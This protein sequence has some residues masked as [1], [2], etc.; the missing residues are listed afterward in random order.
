MSSPS[1]ILIA[2]L[3]WGLGHTTRCLPIIDFLLREGHAVTLAAPQKIL[4][5]VAA[6]FP[7][8]RQILLEGYQIEYS[9]TKAFFAG[10]II[11]Q[12]PKILGTIRREHQWLQELQAKEHFDLIISDNRYGLHHPGLPCVIMTHQLLIKS[13]FGK[14][15][16]RQLQKFHY[17][18]LEKFNVCWVVDE[19]GTINLSGELAHPAHLP[20]NAEYIGILSQMT[21]FKPAEEIPLIPTTKKPEVL[22]LLSGPEPMRSQLERTLLPQC[23]ALSNRY[24]FNFV[25]GNIGTGQQAYRSGN[26]FRYFP[27]LS[28]A[29]LAPLLH[30]ADLVICRSG[31]SSLMDLAILGKKALLIPTPGQTEQEYL[32]HYLRQKSG[33]MTQRQNHI[34][35]ERDIPAA[36]QQMAINLPDVSEK[37]LAAAV[38]RLI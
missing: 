14:A 35:L 8:V 3:D 24:Q 22:V 7:A 1:K 10:K 28:A 36:L 17:R 37:R 21:L 6:T 33:L 4:D 30:S 5:F 13:G 29:A 25:A 16:D 19:P 32:A 11:A 20:R 31:Y 12:I 18:L 2:P 34:I 23:K 26:S 38:R 15:T 27:K 9:K